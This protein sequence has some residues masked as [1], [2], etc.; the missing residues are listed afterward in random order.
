MDPDVEAKPNASKLVP[1]LISL[2]VFTTCKTYRP[3]KLE[4]QPEQAEVSASVAD[5]S[6]R[7][8][9]LT[10]DDGPNKGTD[11]V[12]QILADEQVPASLFLIGVQLHGSRQQQATWQRLRQLPQIEIQNH[13][14]THAHNRFDK[15]YTQPA[16]VVADFVR[17]RD[18]L[19]ITSYIARTPGRNVWRTPTI[20]STDL[21]AC[22]P[23]ADTTFQAGFRLLGWDVEWPFNNNLNL[24][25]NP[26]DMLQKIDSFF[27]HGLTKTPQH[28]VLLAH[29]QAF[30]DSADAAALRYFIQQVKSHSKY[31][32]QK[33]S[34]YPGL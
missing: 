1:L 27:T 34:A 9:Y 23:A 10:F 30:A 8:L 6:L 12:M 33:A 15:F 7:Y 29:D 32:L 11:S 31:R 24:T 14:F 22:A 3:A 16:Q 19:Q 17:C 21:A 18:S 5:S 2:V 20:N 28:L 25:K 26:V 4:P 13:S